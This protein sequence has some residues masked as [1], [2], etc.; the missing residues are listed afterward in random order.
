MKLIGRHR[1]GSRVVVSREVCLFIG[2]Q[3][4]QRRLFEVWREK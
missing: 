4:K 2:A 3:M 1:R